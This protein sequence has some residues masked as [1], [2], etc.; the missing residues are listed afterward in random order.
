MLCWRAQFACREVS[1][2]DQPTT[3]RCVRGSCSYGFECERLIWCEQVL[4]DAVDGLN[5]GAREVFCCRGQPVEQ[6]KI[7]LSASGVAVARAA[8]PWATVLYC[9]ASRLDTDCESA[10][11]LKP[12][13]ISS[14]GSLP[15]VSCHRGDR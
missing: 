10:S 6:G 15:A 1:V 5:E 9:A 8:M 11:L 4:V 2:E 7:L 13:P 12:L 14:L 3:A